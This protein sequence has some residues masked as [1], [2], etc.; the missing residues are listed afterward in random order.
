MSKKS[1]IVTICL[2]I[3]FSKGLYS[4]TKD[5]SSE[6]KRVRKELSQVQEER[7]RVR[8]ETQKDK[9]KFKDYRDRTIKRMRVMRNEKD[10]IENLVKTFE[11]KKDS[12]SSEIQGVESDIKEYK[13]V[14]DRLNQLLISATARLRETAEQLPPSIS[15][16]TSSALISLNDELKNSAVGNVDAIGRLFRIVRDMSS[17]TSTIQ[18]AQGSSP[19]PD[20]RG[21]CYRVRIGTI[22][23]A[24]VN[25]KGTRALL[26]NVNNKDNSDEWI[27]INDA[28]QASKILKAVNV[29]EGKSLPELVTLPFNE[30]RIS[31][32]D[33]ENTFETEKVQE[34][35]D[36]QN[37]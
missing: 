27:V 17:S 3:F 7:D 15:E 19:S 24:V 5:I 22:Y 2:F 26:W 14:Q 18:I 35:S 8:N 4:Q 10:S 29:R 32:L 13:I 1:F 12:L 30:R 20:L 9:K 23:E 34:G 36:E 6:I 16:K 37:N 25:T 28:P 21:M 31:G 33:N 11:M